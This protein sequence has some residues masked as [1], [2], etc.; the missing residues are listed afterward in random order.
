MNLELANIPDFEP[1]PIQFPATEPAFLNYQPD[2]KKIKQAWHDFGAFKNILVI[3]NGGSIS[4]FIGIYNAIGTDKNVH[5]LNNTDPEYISNL[6]SH[7]QKH[8]TLVI[9]I[10]K[11]GENVTQL[12]SVLQ[13]LD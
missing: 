6:K 9:A 10:S 7:L 8:Q 11:S 13:F 1:K 5:I 4:S 3:G 12:E 2:F